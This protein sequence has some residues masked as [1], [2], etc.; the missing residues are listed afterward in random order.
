MCIKQLINRA[1]NAVSRKEMQKN[2]E[3]RKQTQKLLKLIAQ[4]PS[5]ESKGEQNENA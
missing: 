4:I 3:L 5:N 1:I 2:K